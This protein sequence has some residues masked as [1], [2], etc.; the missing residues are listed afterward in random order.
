MGTGNVKSAFTITQ[1]AVKTATIAIFFPSEVCPLINS[2]KKIFL[3]FSPI[4]FRTH[5]RV[6]SSPAGDSPSCIFSII[7]NLLVEK[8]EVRR[9]VYSPHGR[10]TKRKRT[11]RGRRRTTPA[12]SRARPFVR[13]QRPVRR[14]L[15]RQSYSCCIQY[16]PNAKKNQ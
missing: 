10:K 5:S 11:R 4:V 2:E 3:N 13:R 7:K 16:T 14:H 9:F 1:S 15:T 6:S 12:L 8:R